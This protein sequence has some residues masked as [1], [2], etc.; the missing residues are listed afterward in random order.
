MMSSDLWTN[1][2]NILHEFDLFLAWNLDWTIIS[3]KS[4]ILVGMTF[5]ENRLRTQWTFT[6]FTNFKFD[7]ISNSIVIF[8]SIESQIFSQSQKKNY[9]ADRAR[10]WK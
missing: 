9:C 4:I 7:F 5:Y 10:R 3:V 8:Y 6:C 2:Y 1:F